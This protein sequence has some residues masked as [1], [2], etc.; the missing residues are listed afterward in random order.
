LNHTSVERRFGLCR[1]KNAMHR[2]ALWL[3]AVEIAFM[4][5]YQWFQRWR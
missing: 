1:R 3:F 5:I 2:S 4:P